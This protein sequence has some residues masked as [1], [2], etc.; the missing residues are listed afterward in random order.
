MRAAWGGMRAA[1]FAGCLVDEVLEQVGHTMWTFSLPKM[2][3]PYFHYH[4]E[5]R[6]KLCRVAYETVQEMMAAAAIG[7][8][9]F[10][11]GM[12]AFTATAGDLLNI[13][14]HVHAIAPRGGWDSEGVWVPVSYI[15]ND[16]A[17]RLFRAKVLSVLTGEGLLS[18]ERARVLMTWNHNSG[19]SVDD[20]VRFEPED[21]KSMEKVARYLLRPPLSLERMNYSDGDDQVVYRRKGRDGRPSQCQV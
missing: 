19:F 4:P 14:P 11:T 10:R 13:N 16:A 8:K 18:S 2:I 7:R 12:V 5:L 3:R 6:G 20:S 21:R 1:A 15:D 17:E 9:G